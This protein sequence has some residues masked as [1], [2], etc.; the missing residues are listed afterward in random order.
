[1]QSVERRRRAGRNDRLRKNPDR[2]KSGIA[3]IADKKFRFTDYSFNTIV[4]ST[5]K[6]AHKVVESVGGKV[7]ESE[8]I[9]PAQQPKAPKREHGSH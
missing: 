7:T 3:A 1:L 5:L 9:V 2:W 6:R 4:Y 8:I